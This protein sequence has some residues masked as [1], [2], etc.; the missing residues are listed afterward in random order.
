MDY[1][2]LVGIHDMDLAESGDDVVDILGLE[3]NDDSDP[4]SPREADSPP[5]SDSPTEGDMLTET[6]PTT[7]PA[8][9]NGARERNIS[10][11]SVE[12]DEEDGDDTEGFISVDG[13]LFIDFNFFTTLLSYIWVSF[14]RKI[15]AYWPQSIVD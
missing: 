8:N 15:F 6:P 4:E 9:V 10:F 3:S 11:G 2:L 1:S 7:P 5:E 12:L 14:Q 13:E